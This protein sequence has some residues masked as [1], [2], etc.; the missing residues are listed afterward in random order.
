MGKV[1]SRGNGI[2]R[3]STRSAG[4]S[5]PISRSSAA[6]IP[7]RSKYLRSASVA[8]QQWKKSQRSHFAA[9]SKYPSFT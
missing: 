6:G 2:P 5:M 8:S 1:V 4:T 7:F 3:E 9:S